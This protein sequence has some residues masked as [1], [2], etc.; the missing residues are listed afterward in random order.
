MV[1]RNPSKTYKWRDKYV[2]FITAAVCLYCMIINLGHNWI[3]AGFFGL[4]VLICGTIGVS[5]VKK[6]SSNK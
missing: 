1:N 5:D 2:A 6:I 4:G 3:L